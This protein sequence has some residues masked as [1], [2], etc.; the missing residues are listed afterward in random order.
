ML[1]VAEDFLVCVEKSL[2]N[3]YGAKLDKSSEMNG[4]GEL[5]RPNSISQSKICL[6]SLCALSCKSC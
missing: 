4:K 6:T 2:V 1:C 5:K 3:P